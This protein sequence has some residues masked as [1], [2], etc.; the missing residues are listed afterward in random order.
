M[1]RFYGTPASGINLATVCF[2]ELTL[3]GLLASV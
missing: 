2:G 3:L 1:L